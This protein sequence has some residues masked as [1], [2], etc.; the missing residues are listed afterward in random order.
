[1][2]MSIRVSET[3]ATVSLPATTLRSLRHGRP[4]VVTVPTLE[5]DRVGGEAG[6]GKDEA[7]LE[8]VQ[9]AAFGHLTDA[10][11]GRP[12]AAPL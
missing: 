7:V 11:Q 2:M 10:D 4:Y 6:Y 9:L 12:A 1:M 8:R 3:L 5:H